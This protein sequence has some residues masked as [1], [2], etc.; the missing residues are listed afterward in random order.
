MNEFLYG[1]IATAAAVAG[2][3]FLR[4][5]QRT[6]DR[7]FVFFAASFW[8]EALGRILAVSLPGFDDN[9]SNIFLLRFVSYAL[10]L[11]AIFDKNLVVQRRR[12]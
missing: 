5:Y 10:I 9:S 2:L 11:A 1:A 4:Y 7:L 12:R 6:H 3:V 8:L